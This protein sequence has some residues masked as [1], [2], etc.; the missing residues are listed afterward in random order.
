MF[1]NKLHLLRRVM[2]LHTID[3]VAHSLF[4]ALLHFE[5]SSDDGRR[6]WVNLIDQPQRVPYDEIRQILGA[7]KSGG[8]YAKDGAIQRAFMILTGIG[9]VRITERPENI[10]GTPY[11][12]S[13]EIQLSDVETGRPLVEARWSLAEAFVAAVC[14]QV[15]VDS[16]DRAIL[17]RLAWMADERGMVRG[18]Q[19]QLERLLGMS[20]KT[21][22]TDGALEDLAALGYGITRISRVDG[23]WPRE[24][25]IQMEVP[26]G[27]PYR[28][29]N[30]RDLREVAGG[31]TLDEEMLQFARAR[32]NQIQARSRLEELDRRERVSGV[33]E[34]ADKSSSET[35]PWDHVDLDEFDAEDLP[36][37]APANDGS[38]ELAS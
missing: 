19:A 25:A 34:E 4:L 1:A 31:A 13:Y 20:R 30:L 23:T 28:L 35:L 27:S 36:W 15:E 14:A 10:N 37:L 33:V 11:P 3:P 9:L 12:V 22:F 7:R 32:E 24:H 18:T 6:F 38:K 5:R 2:T 21:L 29:V 26:E 17:N 8:Q 16:V